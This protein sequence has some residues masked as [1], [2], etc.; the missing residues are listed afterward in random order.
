[1]GKRYATLVLRDD[2]AVAP[3]VEFLRDDLQDEQLVQEALTQA[4]YA[5]YRT[6]NRYGGPS[7]DLKHI[8]IPVSCSEVVS[9]AIEISR[10]YPEEPD[11]E[12]LQRILFNHLQVD[13]P[14]EA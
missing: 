1:M 5:S 10:K 9:E 13:A 8:P 7:D 14:P 6:Y 4:F 12:V 2:P 3:Y 11:E